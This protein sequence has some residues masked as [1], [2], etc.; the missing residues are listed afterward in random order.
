[1]KRGRHPILRL[2]C[3]IQMTGMP[4]VS[5]LVVLAPHVNVITPQESVAH[6]LE[7]T[8]PTTDTAPNSTAS[9]GNGVMQTAR[10]IVGAACNV[11]K[12]PY[13]AV[14]WQVLG[15]VHYDQRSSEGESSRTSSSEPST[16]SVDERAQRNRSNP[17]PFAS[18]GS[19]SGQSLH[20]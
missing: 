1:M 19:E 11:L 20:Q 10:K 15:V 2:A 6:M 16:R 14:K 3:I 12:E 18:A 5:F 17:D 8:P 4:Y 9:A 13:N 7:S